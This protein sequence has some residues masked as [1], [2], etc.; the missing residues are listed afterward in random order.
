M[1]RFAELLSRTGRKL[2]IP[3]PGRSR[4]LLE[5]AG[6]LEDL[7]DLYRRRGLGEA[8]AVR[9]V[10]EKFAVSDDVLAQLVRLHRSAFRRWMDRFSE[11]AQTRWE[12]AILVALILFVA[13]VS[14]PQLLTTAF[15]R[16]ASSYIWVVAAIT[17]AAAALALGKVYQ[18][19]VK[20]DHRVDHLRTGLPSLLLLGCASLFTGVFGL[21]AQIHTAMARIG[22]GAEQAQVPLAELLLGSSATMIASLLVAV[23]IAVVWFFLISKVKR[24]EQA[25]AALLLE[26]PS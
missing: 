25:E 11:Q 21:M 8:Q 20:K 9:K 1:S 22:G 7:Y 23:F 18:L 24:I 16:E 2:D 10:E 26:V 4:V 12:R 6:D 17:L 14:G 5:L 13:A 3:Q 19:V 15:F